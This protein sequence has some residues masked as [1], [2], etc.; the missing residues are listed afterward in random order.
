MSTRMLSA[1]LFFLIVLLVASPVAAQ[2]APT[3]VPYPGGDPVNLPMGQPT[4]TNCLVGNTNPP[5]FMIANFL[6]PPEEYKLAFNVAA[7]CSGCVGFSLNRIHIL[8]N[9]TSACDIAMAVRL[10]RATFPHSPSCPETGPLYGTTPVWHV[11][12]AGPGTYDVSLPIM[13]P[14]FFVNTTVH[15][16]LRIYFQDIDCV[17][18]GV[19]RLLTDNAPTHCTNWNDFG[20]GWY[21]LF[22]EYPTW[23]GNLLIYADAEC[24][25]DPVPAEGATWGAIKSLYR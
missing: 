12:I 20:T 17:G 4:P 7:P 25:S 6:M 22:Q 19:P 14:C 21:D 15:Y 13:F 2:R 1:I 3:V 5:A 9:T 10:E 24:C 16:M 18:G 11:P 23:P 8:L